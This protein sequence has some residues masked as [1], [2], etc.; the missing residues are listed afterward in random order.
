MINYG[1]LS[2]PFHQDK[3]F[4][5]KLEWNR[6]QPIFTKYKRSQIWEA[7][8]INAL[9]ELGLTLVSGSFFSLIDKDLQSCIEWLRT[10]N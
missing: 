4:H 2:F 7:N 3:L 1:G 8:R 9:S 10:H 6:D 5:V